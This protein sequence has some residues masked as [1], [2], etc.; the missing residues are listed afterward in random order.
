MS[1]LTNKQ[2]LIDSTSLEI[3]PGK[4]IQSKIKARGHVVPQ[5]Q[6]HPLIMIIKSLKNSHKENL[7]FSWGQVK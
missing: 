1:N 6:V 2:K 7:I 5:L 3:S 4:L